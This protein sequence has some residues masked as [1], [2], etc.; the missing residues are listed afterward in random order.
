MWIC[1]LVLLLVC[2]L[3]P[4]RLVCVLCAVCSTGL[5]GIIPA[6][7]VI[8]MLIVGVPTGT[9]V[10]EARRVLG[11]LLLLLVGCVLHKVRLLLLLLLLGPVLLCA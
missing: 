4:M 6:S 10:A 5:D 8:M 7:P 1:V 2:Q 3:L 11:L 9:A